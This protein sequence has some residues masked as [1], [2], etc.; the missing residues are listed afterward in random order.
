MI[1]YE[2]IVPS[3]SRPHLLERAL[4]SLLTQVDQLPNRI[5]V[6]DDAA[7]PGRQGPVTEV[8]A[9]AGRVH[10]VP[11][12]WQ[13]QD[14]ASGHGAALGWLLS[15]ATTEYVLYTQ[16]DLLAVRPLPIGRALA[17]MARHGLHQIRFNKRATMGWK[18]GWPKKEY[19]FASREHDPGCTG[20]IVGTPE[21]GAHSLGTCGCGAAEIC[22]VA[23]HWYFQTGL[24]RRERSQKA[25]EWWIAHTGEWFREHTEVKVNRLMNGEVGE[26]NAAPA[27]DLPAPGRAMDPDERARVQRTFIWGEIGLD[28]FIDNLGGDPADWALFR[29]RGGVTGPGSDRDSQAAERGARP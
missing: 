13:L 10:G 8:L 12:V 21:L 2:L 26:F 17:V 16:D 3:A 28:R 22:T 1:A 19:A 29:P 20:A 15:H 27:F 18:G 14:P 9:E 23:D 25:V 6:H 5:L 7:F 11:V 4:D 24:W